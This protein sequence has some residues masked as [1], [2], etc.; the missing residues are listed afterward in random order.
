MDGNSLDAKD[1]IQPQTVYYKGF[2]VIKVQFYV[3]VAYQNT[4]A[5]LSTQPEVGC[6]LLSH[7]Q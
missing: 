6:S 2:R 1:N 7:D 4:G 5:L 3:L